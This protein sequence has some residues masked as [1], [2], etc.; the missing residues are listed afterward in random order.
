M[1]SLDYSYSIP[2]KFVF[3]LKRGA[4]GE[5]PSL[6]TDCRSRPLRSELVTSFAFFTRWLLLVPKLEWR[7]LHY[8]LLLCMLFELVRVHRHGAESIKGKFSE[9]VRKNDALRSLQRD[10]KNR[11]DVG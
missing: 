10:W 9:L 3:G 8:L 4:L 11:S 5:R 2:F 1:F 7:A 6:P